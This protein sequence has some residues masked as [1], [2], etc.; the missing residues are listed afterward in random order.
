MCIYVAR[1]D[2]ELIMCVGDKEKE[3]IQDVIKDKARWR[4]FWQRCQIMVPY[5]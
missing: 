4:I 5:K 3:K 2:E 1:E